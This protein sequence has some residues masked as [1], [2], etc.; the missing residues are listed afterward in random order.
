MKIIENYEAKTCH[1]Q[2]L[3]S[4]FV[5]KLKTNLIELMQV[6]SDNP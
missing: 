3:N 1:V 5:A 6:Y 2:E 4:H